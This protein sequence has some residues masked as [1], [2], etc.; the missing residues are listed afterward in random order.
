MIGTVT[1]HNHYAHCNGRN[2]SDSGE[3]V[4]HDRCGRDV[5]KREDGKV[6]EIVHVGTYS[7]RKFLC[8]TPQHVCEATEVRSQERATARL[9]ED[10]TI[11]KGCTVIVAR[12]RKVPKGTTGVVFWTG[13]DSWDKPKLGVR[14]EGQEEPVWIAA[15]NCD[16]VSAPE[17]TLT[18]EELAACAKYDETVAKEI[19]KETILNEMDELRERMEA[20]RAE[21]KTL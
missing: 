1:R 13:T 5:V 3:I 10:G 16:V 11:V 4:T 2:H 7:A 6:F 19:R 9:V 18:E 21:Y 14:V 20:L 17:S 8:W 15:G 12:G